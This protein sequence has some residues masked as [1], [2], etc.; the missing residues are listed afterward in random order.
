VGH[1]EYARIAAATNKPRMG[2][3]ANSEKAGLRPTRRKVFQQGKMISTVR[4]T[5]VNWS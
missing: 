2:I 4:T 1:L 3:T 5:K